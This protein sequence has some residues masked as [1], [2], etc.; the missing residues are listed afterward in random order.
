MIGDTHEDKL[1]RA[2]SATHETTICYVL[3]LASGLLVL[4]LL[5]GGVW[6]W[7]RNDISNTQNSISKINNDIKQLNDSIFNASMTI[8]VNVTGDDANPGTI[9]L[10]V[11]T[12][13]RASNLSLSMANPTVIF[14]EGEFNLDPAPAVDLGVDYYFNG[15]TLIGTTELVHEGLVVNTTQRSIPSGISLNITYD[16]VA[17]A[18][19]SLAGY[20]IRF[21]RSFGIISVL[22]IISNGGTFTVSVGDTGA[23]IPTVVDIVK[24]KTSITWSSGS[25]LFGGPSKNSWTYLNIS[26]AGLLNT[27][28]SGGDVVI[29]ACL[30]ETPSGA[31]LFQPTRAGSLTIDSSIIGA[32]SFQAF[33]TGL[34]RFI[35]VIVL[36]SNKFFF[37]GDKVVAVDRGLYFQGQGA[38]T[39]SNAQA[40]IQGLYMG[41]G[42][43]LTII[44]SRVSISTMFM[45]TSSSIPIRISKMSDVTLGTFTN[46]DPRVVVTYTNPNWD[47]MDISG[48][49]NLRIENGPILFTREYS[50]SGGFIRCKD[51]SIIIQSND[52]AFTGESAF[53]I[54]STF[55]TMT[56]KSSDITINQ[57]S[58]GP[59]ARILAVNSNLEIINS[60]I[61]V[62]N[63]SSAITIS[64][65][66]LVFSNSAITISSNDVAAISLSSSSF[67]V[68]DE[69]TIFHLETKSATRAALEV[70]T[71]SFIN[72]KGT[73]TIVA[74]NSSCI[75]ASYFSKIVHE[76]SATTTLA[77]KLREME[78]FQ[79]SRG[80][81]NSA[82]TM[83][84]VG[85]AFNTTIG[86]I[87]IDT[88]TLLSAPNTRYTDISASPGDQ[89]CSVRIT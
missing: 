39:I 11:R 19:D 68:V 58:D 76:D 62:V 63:V 48:G 30:I 51:S 36:D 5:F 34:L 35:R 69:N 65:G 70:E 3:F 6:G 60:E 49:S 26:F 88:P 37:L 47:L 40:V 82:S 33:T 1:P 89:G 50:L 78:F 23:V 38:L 41:P 85:P 80:I 25:I 53:V 55:C 7:N 59:N 21:E 31:G 75:R 52:L 18:E 67:S 9:D 83:N 81:L 54:S 27:G 22:P 61:D 72:F 32:F 28:G 84:I 77:C 16:N 57:E 45:N 15:A 8:Y 42:T 43:R 2:K 79:E 71:N 17:F 46:T 13:Y 24:L 44:N 73:S 12:F 4:S 86:A 29:L 74:L 14:S 87:V 56:I 10:P 64:G 20:F 66:R